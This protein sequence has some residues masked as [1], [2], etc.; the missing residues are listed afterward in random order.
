MKYKSHFVVCLLASYIVFSQEAFN[1]NDLIAYYPFD[2]NTMDYSGKNN[3]AYPIGEMEFKDD[4]FDGNKKSIELKGNPV[5]LNVP[6]SRS[7]ASIE[8]GFTLTSW[9]FINDWDK[10]WASLLSKSSAINKRPFYALSFGK[11]NGREIDFII[12]GKRHRVKNTAL[13][14]KEWFH[15]TTVV[16]DDIAKFYINGE[17]ISQ[18]KTKQLKFNKNEPLE[19]GRGR[20]GSLKYLNGRLDELY[21]FSRALKENEIKILMENPLLELQNEPKSFIPMDEKFSVLNRNNNKPVTVISGN[22]SYADRAKNPDAQLALGPPDYKGDD[23]PGIQSYTLGCLGEVV[24][25]FTDNALVDVPGPDLFVIEIGPVKEATRLS[26]SKDGINWVKYGDISGGTAMIDL[27]DHIGEGEKYYFVKLEDLGSQCIGPRAGADIDAIAAVIPKRSDKI[28][29]SKI[30]NISN[31]TIN[32]ENRNTNEESF[33]PLETTKKEIIVVDEKEIKLFKKT[34]KIKV[35][36]SY[37]E[38]GDLI[39][40]YL[41]GKILFSDLKVSKKGEVFDIEL[42]SGEN[43][44]QVEALNE[45]TVSPN[46][47]AIRIFVYNQEY[48]IILSAKKGER[49]ALKIILD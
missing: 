10:G 6:N 20:K 48:E 24:L 35:W 46:T 23:H 45:G 37:D 38:D 8:E 11:D 34:V 15:I 33:T 29:L 16:K 39:N 18:T 43:I 36:D 19:I 2:G 14:K 17:L 1:T 32:I 5:H 13:K 25:E 31:K 12:F 42:Q 3:H 28:L 9:V 49:D 41:N 44:I 21:I 40:L 47:S 26:I 4:R 22:V 7:L 27:V 30:S